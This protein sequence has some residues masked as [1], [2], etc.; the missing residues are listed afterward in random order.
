[1]PFAR[2]VTALS[3]PVTPPRYPSAP[4]QGIRGAQGHGRDTFHL[5]DLRDRLVGAEWYDDEEFA[6]YGL[7]NNAITTLRSWAHRWPG[8]LDER[9]AREAD[10]YEGPAYSTLSPRQ[11]AG[12]GAHGEAPSRRRRRGSNHRRYDALSTFQDE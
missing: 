3:A 11:S 1:M 12:R 7:T 9:L 8:D 6:A 2:P 5:D 4:R 10:E